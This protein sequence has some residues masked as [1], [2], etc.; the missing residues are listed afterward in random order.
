MRL[1]TYNSSRH[2]RHVERG[3]TLNII[4]AIVGNRNTGEGGSKYVPWSHYRKNTT[5]RRRPGLS[6]APSDHLCTS[7]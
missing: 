4:Q 1:I 7:S 2:A 6:Y 5:S 3:V